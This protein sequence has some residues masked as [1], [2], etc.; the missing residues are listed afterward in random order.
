MK[1]L[2]VILMFLFSC[3]GPGAEEGTGL[4]GGT[5]SD[6]EAFPE[7]KDGGGRDGGPK[8]QGSDS[9]EG[10]A[11]AGAVPDS[12]DI[13]DAA[14]GSDASFVDAGDAGA[15]DA[16]TNERFGTISISYTE[17]PNYKQAYATGAFY[18]Y[19]RAGVGPGGG[20][21]SPDLD[22]CVF[23]EPTTPCEPPECTPAEYGL[24]QVGAVEVAGFASG[25][26]TLL[27][28]PATLFYYPGGDPAKGTL[29][30]AEFVFAGEYRLDAKGENGFGPFQ[31]ALVSPPHLS[32]VSPSSCGAKF[33]PQDSELD[34]VWSGTGGGPAWLTFMSVDAGY[35]AWSIFCQ[36]SNDG[37]FVVPSALMEMLPKDVANQNLTL[38]KSANTA[39]G[40]PGMDKGFFTI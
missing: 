17:G 6:A 10:A 37:Q 21:S 3:A 18:D 20:W 12:S 39:F 36:V 26:V 32:L 4:D 29:P 16:G 24:T 1:L 28:D 19:Y 22:A 23:V 14:G 7:K 35:R 27:P 5:G 25:K 40:I 15:D 33:I 31:A 34:V 8:D 9:A 11:D 30:A 2:V 13:P 38:S